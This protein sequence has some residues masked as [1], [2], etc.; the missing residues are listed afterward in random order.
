M[1]E[2]QTNTAE[3]MP[4]NPRSLLF[5][6]GARPERMH[7]A[8][9]SGADVVILD[10]EDSVAPERK[11][12]ARD[13][14][15]GFLAEHVCPDVDFIVRIN[16]LDTMDCGRDLD[17]LRGCRLRALML[18]KS[19]GARS[20]ID[21][22]E[23][24]EEPVPVLPIAAET[25]GSIFSLESFATVSRHLSSL[26]W[27]AEDLAAAIGAISSRTSDGQFLPPLETARNL[28]LFA[29]FAAGVAAIET[30]YADVKNTSGLAAGAARA[31][32]EGF[33]GMMA[34]HPAQVPIINAAFTPTAGQVERATEIVNL[35]AV[36]PGAGVLAHNGKMLDRPHLLRAQAILARSRRS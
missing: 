28:V 7:K 10:L 6:P 36:N 20:V 9:A 34:I 11:P 31:A 8:A 14:I 1:A 15:A 13:A 19:E 16:P 22:V 12:F 32:A 33:S 21:L 30:V 29:A 24:L 26:T 4:A 17:R 27:G 23:R 25:P 5:V 35:F 2:A 18:P 3:E